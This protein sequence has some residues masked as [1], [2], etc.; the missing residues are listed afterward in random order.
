MFR[1]RIQTLAKPLA[2]PLLTLAFVF[3]FPRAAIALPD[4]EVVKITGY[5]STY[6]VGESKP[7]FYF[8]IKNTGNE[9]IPAL[10]PIKIS[11]KE[12]TYQWKEFVQ[13]CK[14]SY[15]PGNETSS[16]IISGLAPGETKVIRWPVLWPGTSLEAIKEGSYKLAF[17]LD[18][19]G[20]ASYANH[21]QTVEFSA[22]YP[23]I[24]SLVL[25]LTGKD[26]TGPCSYDNPITVAEGYI[27]VPHGSGYIDYQLINSW[28]STPYTYTRVLQNKELF[29]VKMNVVPNDDLE[30]W[31]AIQ[32]LSP[33]G[34]M[35]DK[36]YSKIQCTNA[37]FDNLHIKPKFQVKPNVPSKPKFDIN[38]QL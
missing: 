27:F 1:H 11:L 3:G 33:L 26:Y 18:S 12:C 31:T 4:L 10:S 21:R 38:P 7:I 2:L 8:H 37:T 15:A 17:Y 32:V 30:G 28:S 20:D 5:Q 22:A 19:R 16:T 25:S 14:F 36:A 13:G 23:G 34:I 24:D 6:T 9:A 35:S 29:E